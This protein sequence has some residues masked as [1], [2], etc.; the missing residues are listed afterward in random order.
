M[1]RVLNVSRSGVLLSADSG[2]PSLEDVAWSL[3]RQ[4]RF[5]GSTSAEGLTVLEHSVVVGC[6]L[7]R[8]GLP[9]YFLPGLLHDVSETTTGDVIGT[10]K[11]YDIERLEN[12]LLDRYFE[13]LGVDGV[14]EQRRSVYWKYVAEADEDSARAEGSLYMHPN[15]LRDVP[16]W[17]ERNAPDDAFEIVRHVRR[18][19]RAVDV[20]VLR[21][22]FRSVVAQLLD[23]RDPREVY[24]TWYNP[25]LA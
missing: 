7:V 1:S 3:S 2:V 9:E 22:R 4:I 16:W 19:S 18:M 17:N 5:A 12:R 14:V 25:E 21:R 23:L 24:N 15:L 6:L 20:S 8:R 10:V 13:A 11:N